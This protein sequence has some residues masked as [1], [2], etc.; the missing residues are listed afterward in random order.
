MI[1]CEFMVTELLPTIRKE[2]VSFLISK[3]YSQREISKI[4]QI[5][6]AA[7]SQYIKNKRGMHKKELEKLISDY[8]QK[9][10]DLNQ[11]FSEN[12]C[13]MCVYFRKSDYFC[14]SHKLVS[15]VSKEQCNG[16]RLIT[17]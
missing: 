16:C 5:S 17:E 11:S 8:I 7:V 14:K 12:V 9:N 3:N 13:R 15:N 6:E 10:Y 4:L 1:P 2:T